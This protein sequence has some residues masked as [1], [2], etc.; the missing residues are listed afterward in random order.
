MPATEGMDSRYATIPQMPFAA[1][2][3]ADVT[4]VYEIVRPPQPRAAIYEP[5][6]RLRISAE[7]YSRYEPSRTPHVVCRRLKHVVSRR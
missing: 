3:Q 4:P 1:R 7:I 6:S 5:M 2:E